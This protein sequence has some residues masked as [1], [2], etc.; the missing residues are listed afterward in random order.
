MKLTGKVSGGK[1]TPDLPAAWPIAMRQYEGKDVT[2]EIEARKSTRSVKQNARYWTC[3]V[4]LAQHYLNLK[5]E[6]LP[7]LNRDQV[8]WVLAT[9]FVGQEE[10]ELGP[11]PMR[12][13]SLDTAQFCAFSDQVERWLGTVGYCIPDGPDAE[14]Q[15]QEAMA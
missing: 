1:F 15:I 6:G 2:V 7:P 12:T 5:R 10:T 9:A 13:R 14:V 3:I 8:H 4:P 11:V